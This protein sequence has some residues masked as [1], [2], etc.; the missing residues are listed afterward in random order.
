MKVW[1]IILIIYVCSIS[2]T[3]A[4][5]LYN[6]FG[7]L[8]GTFDQ[9]SWEQMDAFQRMA[10][11]FTAPDGSE[12][13]ALDQV[14]LAIY[15]PYEHLIQAEISISE[16]NGGIPSDTNI[17][18]ST[19][20]SGIASNMQVSS[21][22]AN[23]ILYSGNTY[24]L[25]YET[26]NVYCFW[27]HGMFAISGIRAD[28]TGTSTNDW[29]DWSVSSQLLPAA[30]IHGHAAV[31]EYNEIESFGGNG[32]IGWSSSITSGYLTI[33]WASTLDGGWTNEWNSMRNIPAGET[34]RIKMPSFYRVMWHD[35]PLQ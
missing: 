11:K 7:N 2:A 25:K 22:P 1:H 9:T 20:M 27:H 10:I 26:R 3:S 14:D 31:L 21:W 24:W 18:T 12:A 17:W 8:S 13:W 32:W 23:G 6:S 16:D 28:A 30:Y 33:E 35:N 19:D 29:G 4:T 15:T 5:L 34:N